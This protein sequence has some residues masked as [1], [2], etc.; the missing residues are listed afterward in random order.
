M[1]SGD[2]HDRATWALALPFGALWWPWLGLAGAL[3]AASSFL[4]GGLLL[5]PDLDTRS[6]ATRRWGPLKLLWWPYRRL[7]SHRSL[8]SHTPLIGSSGR[9]LYLLVLAVGLCRLAQPL[10]APQPSQLLTTAQELWQQQRPL[11]IAA[12]AGVEASAWLHLIQDGD[13]VPRR[14]RLLRRR[15]RR[16]S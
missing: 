10:G 8:I 11:L 12:L 7:L 3:I 9:L 5:S 6:N 15:R 13:P 14:P 16:R 2:C 4:A 1:A